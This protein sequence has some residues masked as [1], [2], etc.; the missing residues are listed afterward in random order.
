MVTDEAPYTSPGPDEVVI[1]TRAV[2]INPADVGI[3]KAGVLLTKYPAILGCDAA[4]IVEEVGFELKSHFKPGDR[5]I[6]PTSPLKDD[7]KYSGFQDYVV[8]KWPLLAKIPDKTEFSDGA[9][10]P[11]GINTAA[12]CLFEK[13]LLALEFPP[14]DTGHG[15]TLLIW[16]AS[17]SVGACG[18]QL[19]T[20]AGYDVFAIASRRNHDFLRSIGAIEC[21]DY[22]DADLTETMIKSLTGRD[23]VGAYD[24]ISN[25]STLDTLCDILHQSGGRQLI[26]AVMPGAEANAKH[27]V[28]VKTNFTIDLVAS[29][30]GARIW[31]GFVGSAL[32]EGKLQCKPDV[33]IVG[34]G[35]ESVQKAVDLLAQGVSA[36]KLV[37]TL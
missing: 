35:L 6:G 37:V 31:Q 4:G 16:G 12:M 2:A 14:G 30:T 26:A 9:V 23:I 27:N 13:E 29:G 28:V 8:L 21:F 11:L 25:Q 18:V 10:L 20:A 15:K 22:N 24:A 19:A 34:R 1:R 36:K 5:V 33:E 17:S 3:Q 7:Y 32:A